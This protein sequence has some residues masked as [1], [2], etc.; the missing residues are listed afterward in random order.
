MSS[1][2]LFVEN[3]DMSTGFCLYFDLFL[4]VFVIVEIQKLLLF[5]CLSLFLLF[6]LLFLGL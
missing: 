1:L 2:L 6:Y 5:V 3:F 4:T